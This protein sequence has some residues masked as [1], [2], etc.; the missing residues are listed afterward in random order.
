[1][2]EGRG[3]EEGAAAEK[4]FSTMA[5]TRRAGDAD[6]AAAAAAGVGGAGWKGSSTTLR[7]VGCAPPGWCRRFVGASIGKRGDEMG[8]GAWRCDDSERGLRGSAALVCAC[9]VLWSPV[10][11]ATAS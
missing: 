10:K 1:M 4:P 3:A 5:P 8:T 9:L 2:T 7:R 6:A 11:V